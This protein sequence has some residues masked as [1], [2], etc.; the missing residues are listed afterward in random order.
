MKISI[1]DFGVILTGKKLLNDKRNYI[2][3]NNILFLCMGDY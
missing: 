1:F 2:T 3:S